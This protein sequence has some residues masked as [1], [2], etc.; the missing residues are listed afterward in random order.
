[1]TDVDCFSPMCRFETV[2]WLLSEAVA[3]DWDLVSTDIKNAFP[4]SKL[5]EPVWMQ[6]PK[7][8]RD[9]RDEHGNLKHPELQDC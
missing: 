7:C 6:I 9:E 2:R 1:M 8:I 5:P 4:T 3:R